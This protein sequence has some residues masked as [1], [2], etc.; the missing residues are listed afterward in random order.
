[1]TFAEETN[2]M[3]LSGKDVGHVQDVVTD[4]VGSRKAR[5]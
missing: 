5:R 4:G 1:M 3:T 2:L